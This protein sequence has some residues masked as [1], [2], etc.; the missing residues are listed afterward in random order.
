MRNS[1]KAREAARRERAVA[2]IRYER[3]AKARAILIEQ[4]LARKNARAAEH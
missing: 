2:A 4:I 3:D 1:E